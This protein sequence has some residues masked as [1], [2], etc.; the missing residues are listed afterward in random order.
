MNI[1]QVEVVSNEQHIYS[2]EATFVVV[3]TVT[4][5]LGIYPRHEP[6][7]SLVRPGT[8]RLTSPGQAEEILVAVSGGLLEVQPDKLTVLA[9]V[10]VR[11]SEMDQARAEEA[12]KAAEARISQ[13]QDDEALAKAHAA[14]AAAIAQLKTLDYIRAQKNK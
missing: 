1:M 10:A 2:G 5:E 14:L 8:L 3:P 12:K 7:M 9:D 13:A 4:G 11:S 6:I